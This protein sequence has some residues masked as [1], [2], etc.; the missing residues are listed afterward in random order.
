[1]P[2]R[3]YTGRFAPT[4]SGPLH[5]GS[6]VAALGSWLD[7]RASGGRWLL[8][9]EDLDTQRVRPGSEATILDALERLGLEWDGT[10]E[11]QGR[12][13]EAY[14]EALEHL[15]KLGLLYACACPRRLLQ[16]GP[17]P[18]TCRNLALEGPGT[19]LRLRLEDV[20]SVFTDLVQGRQS[21]NLLHE[22]GDF[23]VRRS[24]GL[25]AYNLASPVDDARQ[26]VT[27]VVRGADLLDTT[28]AQIHLGQLL[29]LEQPVYCHLPVALDP[30][31]RKM[32]KR[33]MAEDALLQNSPGQLLFLALE[34]LGQQPPAG[35]EAAQPEDL[36]A[37]GREN[38]S[39]RR[40][41]ASRPAPG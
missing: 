13:R 21:L 33:W 27:H 11:Y 5:F 32:S 15:R 29:G 23:I 36:L 31:G 16:P 3:T 35:F 37:W 12:R 28:H 1:M 22:L 25:H 24:D 20:E 40:V 34:F 19:A 7:A 18:G 38:W 14:G 30:L 8:R 39:L 10:I 6:I 4:P 41:P 9:I 26:G 2:A 17:Y